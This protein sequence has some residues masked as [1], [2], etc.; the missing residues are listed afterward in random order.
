MNGR[1]AKRIRKR[2]RELWTE[3]C[4]EHPH[5]KKVAGRYRRENIIR[6]IGGRIPFETATVVALGYRR[7][8][9]NLKWQHKHG[10]VGRKNEQIALNNAIKWSNAK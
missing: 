4:E 7:L 5:L 8:V 3:A 9:K 1:V 6:V 2:A 10:Y